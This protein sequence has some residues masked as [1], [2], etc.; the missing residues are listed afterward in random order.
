MITI[1]GIFFT[2]VDRDW[3]SCLTAIM[4]VDSDSDTET[5]ER[6]KWQEV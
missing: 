5:L 3:A 2:G 4:V 6:M 1:E